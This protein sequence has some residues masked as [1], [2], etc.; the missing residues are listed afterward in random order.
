MGSGW[1]AAARGFAQE[2]GLPASL[3]VLCDRSRR[4]FALLGLRRSI[5][6][7]L[8]VPRVLRNWLALR[9]RG[10]KQGRVKGDP[11]QQGGAAVISPGGR[12]AYRFAG[13]TPD[14]IPDV[15]AVLEAVRAARAEDR[16]VAALS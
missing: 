5:A 1:P 3:P 15:A 9:R 14:D 16:A 8:L 10:F 13:R 12:L 2:L 4:S 7:T 11:W 6:A